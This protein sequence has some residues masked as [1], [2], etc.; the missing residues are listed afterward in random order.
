MQNPEPAVDFDTVANVKQQ[1]EVNVGKILNNS[2]ANSSTVR[3]NWNS[4]IDSFCISAISNSFG[5]GGHNSV[6]AFSAFR[7]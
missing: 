6:V 4:M 1:H 3:Y 5:F 7:P 2:I